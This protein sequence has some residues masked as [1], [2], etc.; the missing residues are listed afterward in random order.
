MIPSLTLPIQAAGVFQNSLLQSRK[1]KDSAWEIHPFK[2]ELEAQGTPF[3]KAVK[4]DSGDTWPGEGTVHCSGEGHF[5]AWI[6]LC[7]S[8]RPHDLD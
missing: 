8:G 5:P 2:K 1:E 3:R 6:T 7:F 4:Q